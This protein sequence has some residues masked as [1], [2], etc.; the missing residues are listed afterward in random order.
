MKE[1]NCSGERAD[2]SAISHMPPNC[3]NRHSAGDEIIAWIQMFNSSQKKKELLKPFSGVPALSV[4]W[5]MCSGGFCGSSSGSKTITPS[6]TDI[7]L[8]Y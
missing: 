6:G 8:R 1:V 7:Y 4:L 5:D 3:R 2:R